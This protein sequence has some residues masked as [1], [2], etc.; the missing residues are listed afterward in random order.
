[1]LIPTVLESTP[2][3]ERAYDIWSRLLRER[4]VFL[5]TA[6]DDQSANLVIAQLLFLEGPRSPCTCTSTARAAR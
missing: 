6:I 4:I 3:G 5:G 1:V 2:R